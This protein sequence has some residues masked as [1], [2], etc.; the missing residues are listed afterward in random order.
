[1][2]NSGEY[3]ACPR[4]PAQ[5]RHRCRRRNGSLDQR[6]VSG[7]AHRAAGRH[8][9]PH[10]ARQAAA[11]RRSRPRRPVDPTAQPSTYRV[12][13]RSTSM[14]SARSI[15]PACSRSTKATGSR[16]RSPRPATAHRRRPISTRVVVTRT[17]DD[18]KTASHPVDLYQALE[19]GDA[20]FDPR[21]RKGDTVYVPIAK[22]S[23]GNLT[24]AVFLLTRLLFL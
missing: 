20:R 17:E 7:R 5:R 6:R 1:M 2:T 19:K 16:S 14:F 13:R 3:L 10:F 23:H 11:R 12:R 24:N 18:G 8:D 4:R 9:R 22:Q 15:I 21:M